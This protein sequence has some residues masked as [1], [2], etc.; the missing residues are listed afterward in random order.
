MLSLY[1]SSRSADGPGRDGGKLPHDWP[2]YLTYMTREALKSVTGSM[3]EICS[4]PENFFL[5]MNRTLAYER[6]MRDLAAW[7]ASMPQGWTGSSPN[8]LGSFGAMSLWQ[9][10]GRQFP[11]VGMTP[12]LMPPYQY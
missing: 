3:S 8:Q 4:G 1:T 9:P 5:K 2:D 7:T 6:T 12:G 10:R 11:F